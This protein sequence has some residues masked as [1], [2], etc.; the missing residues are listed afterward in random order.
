M[1]TQHS[2]QLPEC[3]QRFDNIDERQ[4]DLAAK[5]DDIHKLLVRGNGQ[6]PYSV[7][8]DRLEQSQTNTK[9]LARSLVVVLIGMLASSIWSWHASVDTHVKQ[10]PTSQPSK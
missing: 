8:L 1:A 2:S 7:R 3:Q 5:V 6:A 9:W 4:S 10:V